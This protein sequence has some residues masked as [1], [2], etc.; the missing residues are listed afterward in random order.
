MTIEDPVEYR[1]DGV[2]QIQVSERVG[3][4]F[5]AGLRAILRADPDV[6]MVGEMRDRDSAH[7]AIDAALTGH[8]VLSTLHTN[9]AP[10]AP[11]RLVDM[12]IEP[13]LVASAINC[14]IA[15]RLARKLCQT[16]R[17]PMTVPGAHVDLPRASRSSRSSTR[18]AARA[19]AR[20][21][22]RAHR[23]LRDHGHHRRDPP[24]DRHPRRRRTR[25]AALAIEEGMTALRDDGM[26]KVRS[27]RSRRSP[28][29]AEYSADRAPR[30][31]RHLLR[32]RRLGPAPAAHPGHRQRP[33]PRAGPVRV[34]GRSGLR[35]RL[36]RSPRPRPLP[37]ARPERPAVD[38][39]LRGGRAGAG[40][41]FV[42]AALRAGRGFVWWDGR[43]GDRDR[44]ARARDAH[45]ARVHLERRCGRVLGA[46]ARGA[47]ASW[48]PSGRSG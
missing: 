12:G 29:W 19:A 32:A 40:G 34:A 8:L 16:C 38:G 1:L 5:G 13:Y 20:P 3:L 15:Q 14:V 43:A 24:A 27:R 18:T 31:R 22:T 21:A 25:C 10:G 26:A 17:K 35:R 23:R 9:D 48:A 42:M 47:L 39:G 46:T 28:R 7:M 33:A 44:R 11:M 30:R 41:P 36:L 37:R 45:G 4:S 2:N 6:I